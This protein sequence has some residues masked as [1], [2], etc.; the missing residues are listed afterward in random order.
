MPPPPLKPQSVAPLPPPGSSFP[1]PPLKLPPPPGSDE[2]PEVSVSAAEG[3]W[4]FDDDDDEPT[5]AFTPRLVAPRAPA[6]PSGHAPA[7]PSSAPPA[8]AGWRDRLDALRSKTVASF[9][10]L[11]KAS[12]DQLRKISSRPPPPGPAQAQ[13]ASRRA[14][15]APTLQP[16]TAQAQ[17][18]PVAR[19]AAFA[20]AHQPARAA[21]VQADS[22]MF[23]GAGKSRKKTVVLAALA[24]AVVGIFLLHRQARQHQEELENELKQAKP[25]LWS[26]DAAEVKKISKHLARSFEVSGYGSL[27]SGVVTTLGLADKPLFESLEP[28]AKLLLLRQ[29]A[30]LRLLDPKTDPK[31]L[32]TL[33]KAV[34]EADVAPDRVRFA[35]LLPALEAKPGD[36]SEANELDASLAKDPVALL[37]SGILLERVGKVDEARERYEAAGR[38]RPDWHLPKVYAARLALLSQGADAA[39]AQVEGIREAARVD[40]NL[41]TISRALNALSWVVDSGRAREL[42]DTARLEPAERESL[43]PVLGQVPA[44]VKLVRAMLEE[45]EDLKGLLSSAIRNADG[46]ALLVQLAGFAA[47]VNEGDLVDDAIERVQE[48]AKGYAPAK[49][50]AAR[51]QLS[52]GDFGAARQTAKAAGLDTS[53][54]DAVEAYELQD[55][56]NLHKAMEAMPPAEKKKPEYA[57]IR[58]AEGVLTGSDY[59]SSS[60]LEAFMKGNGLWADLVAAD[61]ALDQGDLGLARTII[62][63]WPENDRTPLHQIRVARYERYKGR[64]RDAVHLSKKALDQASTSNR[65][66]I[67]YLLALLADDRLSEAI[68]L[69]D[70]ELYKDMLKPHDR[71][72]TALLVGKDKG[73]MAANVMTSYLQPPTDAEPLSLQLLAVRS[74][75]VAGDPRAGVY[76]KRMEKLVP[77]NPDYLTAKSEY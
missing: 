26:T 27:E 34:D 57:A 43:P 3:E 5:R 25:L 61:A 32:Q 7:A 20:P 21:E 38:Q 64:S 47:S 68:K 2:G 50:L 6:V 17:P 15:G 63:G 45:D 4:D 40:P 10:Q 72:V 23:R 35:K 16:S 12:G 73:W 59:P 30:V 58:A 18:T 37:L 8:G 28:E 60:E 29:H 9:E 66:L 53:G 46:P 36:V 48:F 55:S 76:L 19:A 11:K 24:I 31:K 69:Y 52:K 22:A 67:E 74:M 44:L 75:S 54:I 33:L 56:K 70:D 49:A 39:K 65:A 51:M 1:S 14:A 71:W 41:G 42:P 77:E 13:P 62:K